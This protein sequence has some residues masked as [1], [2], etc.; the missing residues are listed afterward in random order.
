MQ[1]WG[2]EKIPP[3]S[4]PGFGW[5]GLVCRDVTSFG[6][7]KQNDP[8]RP[9]VDGRTSQTLWRQGYGFTNLLTDRPQIT[10]HKRV[11]STDILLTEMGE[12]PSSATLKEGRRGEGMSWEVFS[13]LEEDAVSHSSSL[14]QEGKVEAKVR[15][16]FPLPLFLFLLPCCFFFAGE[17][18]R[19]VISGCEGC[20][21]SRW[22]AE[23]A[24]A[25]DAKRKAALIVL[26]L[27]PPP[28]PCIVGSPPP[29]LLS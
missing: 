10:S 1:G 12:F 26:P 21:T 28:P 17:R 20:T 7:E 23:A 24:A 4:N 19:G 11:M 14:A 29:L 27:P 16:L 9:A 6:A 3:R 8:T 5:F 22:V 2:N 25:Q 13:P 15:R 18:G